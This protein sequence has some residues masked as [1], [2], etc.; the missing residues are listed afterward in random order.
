MEW[1]VWEEEGAYAR[2]WSFQLI[3]K[4]R[5]AK[6]RKYGKGLSKLRMVQVNEHPLKPF[7][8][9]ITDVISSSKSSPTSQQSRR[10]SSTTTVA[11]TS[12]GGLDPLS[13]ALSEAPL[14]P[15][16]SNSPDIYSKGHPG[17][18]L[19][20]DIFDSSFACDWSS[21]KGG[22]LANY[23]T[24]EKLSLKSSF[25][26]G[27]KNGPGTGA[28][29][30]TLQSSSVADKV[31]HRLEQ[32]DD[33]EEGSVREMLNLSQQEFINRID[34]L[35]AA[36][37]ESWE[38]DQRVKALKIAIQCAKLLDDVTVMQFYPSKF[39]L[40]TDILDNFGSLVFKRISGKK[41]T[42]G[43]AALET[44][45]NWF[46]KIASIRELVPRF[47]VEAAILQT[48][49]FIIN[50]G[51]SNLSYANVLTRLSKMTRGIGNP[52][53]A[54][55]ARCYLCRVAMQVAPLEKSVIQL[56]LSDF[57]LSCDQ[58][59]SKWQMRNNELPSFEY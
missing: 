22:I 55:Y 38:Q 56:N 8:V 2:S 10:Q 28:L 58:V 20:S 45:R 39:V 37:K 40:V 12:W 7:T 5:Y 6:D 32:L 14:S 46:Y 30:T 4:R 9:K 1:W 15:A 13:L 17:K 41:G 24:S 27:G 31:K 44:C 34:E 52:L 3:S 19:D 29:R 48:Y 16:Q 26:T 42:V 53:V 49:S 36:L 35:N 50:D 54:M 11:S 25:L 59:S 33:F 21:R 47:F 57:F 43:E 51:N 18:V 23:T